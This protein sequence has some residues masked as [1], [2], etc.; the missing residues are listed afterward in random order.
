MSSRPWDQEGGWDWGLDEN[1]EGLVHIEMLDLSS[2][3]PFGWLPRYELSLVLDR[4]ALVAELKKLANTIADD[5]VANPG[6]Y[7]LRSKR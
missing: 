6:D 7:G 5:I 4:D 2:E 3:T 1:F